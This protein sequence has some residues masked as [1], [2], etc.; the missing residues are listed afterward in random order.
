[1]LS[2]SWQT[3][4]K[5]HEMSDT[6]DGSAARS[7]QVAGIIHFTSRRAAL[8]ALVL[9]GLLAMMGVILTRGGASGFVTSGVWAVSVWS[10]VVT[11]YAVATYWRA[12][13]FGGT[14]LGGLSLTDPLT[15][16]PNRKGLMAQLERCDQ[17][18]QEF[19]RRIRLV[20]VDLINLNRVNYEYGQMVGDAVLQD[21]GNVLRITVPEENLVGR[22]GGDEFLVI[23]PSASAPECEALAGNIREA[24]SEYKLS[25]G[26]R[27]EVS[28]LKASVSVAAYI[29]EQASLH[30]TVVSAKEATAH[31]DIARGAGDET[32]GYYHVQR[33][34]LGAFAVFRWQN[35]GKEAQEAFKVWKRDLGRETTSSMASDIAHMLDER[36]DSGSV[37]FVTAVPAAGGIGGGRTYP[38]RELAQQ[39][40]SIVGVPYRDVMRADSSGPESR[41]V[42]P[43]VDAVIDEGDAVLLVSDVVSSGILERRCVKK[44]SAAGAHI[45]VV[46]WAA[47]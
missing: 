37:D 38:A 13:T 19:G 4:A 25:L 40:A 12:R 22:L 7:A 31:G 29:P 35:L 20:D 14:D 23:M 10:L 28:N 33:V 43:A 11:V 21:I 36:A 24:I 5:V 47:Y 44:L 1:L 34:T 27:G 18:P 26:E 45:Q 41:S 42:E 8:S 16:L 6:V 30:E 17:G 9:T 39:V 32:T 3:D 46:S 2:R 15:G